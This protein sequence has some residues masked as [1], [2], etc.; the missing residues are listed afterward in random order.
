MGYVL[1][2]SK[3]ESAITGQIASLFQKR[4]EVEPTAL[5]K[6]LEREVVKQATKTEEGL[7][8]P[9]DYAVYLCEEDCHRLSAARIIKALH[10]A[11][12]RKVIRENYFMDGNLSV[13]IEKMYEGNE[14]IVIKSKF[15]DDANADEDTINLENESLDNTL[16]EQKTIVEENQQTLIADKEKFQTVPKMNYWH[17][18]DYEIAK[19]TVERDEGEEEYILGERQFYIGRK[20]SND[21]VLADESVS[22]IHAFIS[23]D[24]HRHILHDAN[25]LNGT[26]INKKFAEKQELHHGDKIL[27]GNILVTYEAL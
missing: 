15:M 4:G 19:L 2:F 22:R 13:R 12:E 21:L 17:K 3:L 10:E 7:F 25:S 8:V 16:V 26:Y 6:A 18:N 1:G 14:A 9:N 5:I 24:R 20:E 11:V 23:Y 27:I